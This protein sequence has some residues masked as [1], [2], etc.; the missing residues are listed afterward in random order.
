[1]RAVRRPARTPSPQ[2][3][4]AATTGNGPPLRRMLGNSPYLPPGGGPAAE[5]RRLAASA[6]TLRCLPDFE[7][8]GASSEGDAGGAG[9]GCHLLGT[10]LTGDD[11]VPA[12]KLS[13]QVRLLRPSSAKSGPPPLGTPAAARRTIL[14]FGE[15]QVA[16]PVRDSRLRCP[17]L[18]VCEGGEA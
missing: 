2:P 12:G 11:N 3:A 14:G 9:S 13:F 6:R 10:K 18:I 8:E 16:G 17:V 7:G 15:L 1:M 4:A 5:F